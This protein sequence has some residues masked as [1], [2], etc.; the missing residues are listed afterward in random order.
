M[1]CQ[2]CG[3]SYLFMLYLKTLSAAVTTQRRTVMNDEL[4][5]MWKEAVMLYFNIRHSSGWT[6]ENY[7]N[8]H[9]AYSVSRVRF[10]VGTYQIQVRSLT[11]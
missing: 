10:E 8:G 5:R 9:S 3:H 1:S 2:I 7:E 11:A 6:D 4:E